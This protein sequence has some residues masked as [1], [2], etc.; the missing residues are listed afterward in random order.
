MQLKTIL[1]NG[2]MDNHYYKKFT[3]ATKLKCGCDL[4]Y[5]I[6]YVWSKKNISNCNYKLV[7]FVI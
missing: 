6:K 7:I 5:I 4:D 3:E 2:Q 1:Q